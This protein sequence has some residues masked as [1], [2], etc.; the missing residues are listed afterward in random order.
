MDS[1]PFLT[2]DLLKIRDAQIN[3]LYKFTKDIFNVEI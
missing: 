2:I 3:E 1:L